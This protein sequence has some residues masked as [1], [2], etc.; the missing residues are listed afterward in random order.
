MVDYALTSAT[1]FMSETQ[2]PISAYSGL[3]NCY[4]TCWQ[5]ALLPL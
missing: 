2:S 1:N 5:W 3:R 4:R